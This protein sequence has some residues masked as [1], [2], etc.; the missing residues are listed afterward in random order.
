MHSHGKA[1]IT[2]MLN[3]WVIIKGNVLFWKNIQSQP[4]Y[5]YLLELSIQVHINLTECIFWDR[6]VLRVN[7]LT[8][9]LI[10]KGYLENEVILN[11]YKIYIALVITL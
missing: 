9:S 10:E 4:F 11:D 1:N 2:K 3:L 6:K 5:L 8:I 7:R